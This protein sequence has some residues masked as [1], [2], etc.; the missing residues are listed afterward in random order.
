MN[1]K[2]IISKITI[3]EKFSLLSG[4]TNWDTAPVERLGI[5]SISLSDGPHGV[6][7]DFNAANTVSEDG[8]IKPTWDTDLA[9]YNGLSYAYKATCFP[10]A[11]AMSATWN[12]EM[13][14]EVGKA[15]GEECAALNVDII[16]GPGTNIKRTPLCGRNFEYFSEDPYLS[17]E[18]SA[19]YINGVQSKG[20]GTSL[21]HFAGNNQ[22]FDRGD[23]SSEIDI[24]TLREIYLRPFEIA[25]KKA[26]PWTVMCAYN[27]LNGIYCA[28]NKF[29]LNDMLK[30]EF[31]FEGLV[32]S[33]WWAVKDRAKSL[34]G[35]LD[36]EMPVNDKSMTV[37]K[38]AYKKGEISD[39]E[40]NSALER[41]L[42]IV[43]KASE[44]KSS[45]GKE[46]DATKHHEL[47]RRAASEAITLLKNEDEVLPV[48]K[49]KV[50]KIAVIGEF[51]RQPI[52]QGGGSACLTPMEVDSALDRIIELA[53]TD[54]EVDFAAAYSVWAAFPGVERL[55][56]AMELA[57][58]ADVA[59]VFVGE[60]QKVEAEAFDRFNIK[61]SPD[62]ENIILRVAAQNP[63]T[64]VV[65][66]AGSAIDMSAWIHKV[67][68]VV[69]SWFG[70]EAVGSAIADILFGL[71]NPSGKLA[72]TFPLKLEDTPAFGTYPGNGFAVSYTEGIMVG[73]RYYDS[74]EKEVLFPFGHGLS[75]TNFEYSDLKITPDTPLIADEVK[76]SF[77]VKNIGKVQG[78]ET[79][80]I[81]VNDKACR[82]LRPNKELKAFTKIDLQ[83]GEEKQVE[84]TLN[85]EAFEYFNV[86]LNSWYI[87]SGN[88]QI[89]IGS[90]SRDIRLKGKVF[91]KG[92]KDFS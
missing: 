55:G 16:L 90:S 50:K 86:N 52:I 33:D 23:I 69:F 73:Y 40:I 10:T 75:Y 24:R 70:G 89:Q 1:I 14:E 60:S 79:V 88:F 42:K 54:I 56:K 48:T 66:E 5:P 82:T 65:I 64:V 32:V 61:L 77:K 4:R 84:F 57:A 47:A 34:K 27:R 68:G 46:Y 7:K 29:L 39:E 58:D 37:L 67:K 92:E 74:Y 11:S 6:R 31:G 49:E 9:G 13:V 81:Y 85:R 26:K 35:S 12:T 41:V 43:F 44:G 3:E 18:L 76:V 15:L 78:K 19:A 20:I 17:G 72:E 51:A 36:L 80:Q 28:E 91:I 87:E 38:T 59:I 8:T 25:I 63:N 45:R 83:P 62:M 30:E 71:T 22:E 21:K 2:E 53:G